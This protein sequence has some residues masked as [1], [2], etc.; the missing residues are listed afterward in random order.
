MPAS[1]GA[2]ASTRTQEASISLTAFL[3]DPQKATLDAF[4]ISVLFAPNFLMFVPQTAPQGKDHLQ[5]GCASWGK[6]AFSTMEGHMQFLVNSRKFSK[7]RSDYTLN[8]VR[9]PNV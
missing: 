5:L 8:S 2:S 3:P 4:L 6:A 9:S 7:H 1:H